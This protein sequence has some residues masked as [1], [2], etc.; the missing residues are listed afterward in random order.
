MD[1][2]DNQDNNNNLQQTPPTP[3]MPVPPA[4]PQNNMAVASMIVSIFGLLSCCAPPLQF[5]LGMAGLLLAVFSK[6]GRPFSGFAV[7]GMIMSI[8]SLVIS[9][10]MVLYIV[11]ITSLV[12]DPQYGPMINEMMELYEQMFETLPSN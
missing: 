3:P 10:F 5:V 1:N 2:Y 11:F 4:Q 6:K 9:I 12:R 7:A 8:L